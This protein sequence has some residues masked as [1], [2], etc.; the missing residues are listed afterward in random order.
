MLCLLSF[1]MASVV[2]TAA[3]HFRTIVAATGDG[4]ALVFL[5]SSFRHVKPRQRWFIFF[6]LLPCNFKKIE[7]S[8]AQITTTTSGSL[9]QHS[10]PTHRLTPLLPSLWPWPNHCG[11]SSQNWHKG[12][13]VS[14]STTRTGTSPKWHKIGGMVQC[15]DLAL[16]ILPLSNQ[17]IE[18]RL[19]TS[20]PAEA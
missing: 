3:I 15:L 10:P 7:K 4:S 5:L 13:T 19:L 16:P 2:T 6:G 11:S 12:L 17:N 8:Q 9:Q 20:G 1:H 14:L 18:I